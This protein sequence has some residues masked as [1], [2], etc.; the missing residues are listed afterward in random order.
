MCARLAPNLTSPRVPPPGHRSY[1]IVINLVSDARVFP[2]LPPDS[3]V[4]STLAFL[5]DR[6]VVFIHKHDTAKYTPHCSIPNVQ[7]SSTAW[8]PLSIAIGLPVVSRHDP[9]CPSLSIWLT[10]R[11]ARFMRDE[12]FVPWHRNIEAVFCT[13]S[14]NQKIEPGT[15]CGK[16]LREE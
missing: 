13:V 8:Y 9:L 2:I 5:R 3:D 1:G 6:V 15:G 7:L 14:L 10:H 11:H 4:F 16:A 12:R